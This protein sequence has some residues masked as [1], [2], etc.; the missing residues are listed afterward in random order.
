M[1]SGCYGN[2][3]EPI[4][5]YCLFILISVPQEM[6]IRNTD[7]LIREADEDVLRDSHQDIDTGAM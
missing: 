6:V 1:I 4:L 5:P 3:W 7:E 2:E